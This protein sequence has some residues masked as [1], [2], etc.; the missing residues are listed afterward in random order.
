MGNQ[1]G[2]VT[3]VVKNVHFASLQDSVGP[4][5]F[6]PLDDR[7]SRI[8]LSAEITKPAQSLA[9]IESTW[10]KHFPSI[11]LDYNFL[12][13]QPWEQYQSEERFSKIILWF[14]TLSL[15]IA[16]LGLYGLIAYAASQKT[17]EIGVRKVLG[18]TVNGI[19]LMFSKDFLKL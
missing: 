9:W 17:K 14:S 4:L 8:T 16:C 1:Q 18:A 2:T 15:L 7:F 12:D 19:A 3:G 5:A 10:K 6:H 13:N 11:L